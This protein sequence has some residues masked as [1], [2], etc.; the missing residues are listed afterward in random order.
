MINWI[1]TESSESVIIKTILSQEIKYNKTSESV[2]HELLSAFKS[3]HN[4]GK[5]T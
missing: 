3:L 5:Q 2:I 1:S 4:K